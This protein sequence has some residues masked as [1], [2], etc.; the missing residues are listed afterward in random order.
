MQGLMCLILLLVYS[1][2]PPSSWQNRLTLHLSDSF[3]FYSATA[4]EQGEKQGNP[5]S[6]VLFSEDV[7][8]LSKSP[9]TALACQP[10]TH[11]KWGHF[12]SHSNGWLAVAALCQILNCMLL[13]E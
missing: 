6:T 13:L 4:T 9:C 3:I 8:G 1:F 7:Y 11:A 5:I 10:A 2:F 12:L